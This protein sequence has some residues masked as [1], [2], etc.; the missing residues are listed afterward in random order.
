MIKS[1]QAPPASIKK[2]SPQLEVKDYMT[3]KLVTLRPEQNINE[4]IDILLSKKISGAPVVD[5][6]G[7]LLGVLSE[8][9][10][11]KELVKGQ[12]N[13]SLQKSSLV[14]DLMTSTVITIEAGLSIFQAAERFLNL[15]VRRFPVLEEGKLVGQIS[16][17]DLMR[18]F[19]KLKKA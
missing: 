8:G 14:A 2:E 6:S 12:Y 9:D 4:A 17:K 15:K 18:A 11:L 19:L 13:N 5:E 16:Q 10:C 1:Y 7:R 3:K